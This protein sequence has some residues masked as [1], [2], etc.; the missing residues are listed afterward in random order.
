MRETEFRGKRKDKMKGK[1]YKKK[2]LKEFL[3]TQIG[4]SEI[5]LDNI[6]RKQYVGKIIIFRE[7]DF[8]QLINTIKEGK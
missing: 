3:Y 6:N 7:K 4:R 1:K 8:F 2:I 5:L